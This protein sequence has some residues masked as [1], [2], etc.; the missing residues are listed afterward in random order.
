[1]QEAEKILT[2]KNRDL[3]II[4]SMSLKNKNNRLVKNLI[5]KN[6]L[7]TNK[8][9]FEKF[10]EWVNKKE[11]GIDFELFKKDFNFQRP[12]DMLKTVYNTNDKKKNND[13]VIMIKSGLSDFKKEIG[14]MNE[15]EKE[16]EKPNVIPFTRFREFLAN[17]QNASFACITIREI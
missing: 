10:N 16:I 11:A 3:L 17:L 6:Y 14:N 7:K 12:S 9:W 4:I 2:T 13:L 8:R 15:E 1:M 5:K